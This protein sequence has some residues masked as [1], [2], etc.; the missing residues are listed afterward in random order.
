[1]DNGN[2]DVLGVAPDGRFLVRRRT[3]PAS[4]NA[5]IVNEWLREVRSLLGPPAA[6][7]PR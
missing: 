1:M 6:S 5:V 2:E 4:S 3:A 7:M